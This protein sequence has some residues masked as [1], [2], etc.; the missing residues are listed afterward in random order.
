MSWFGTFG[1]WRRRK[2]VLLESPKGLYV[3]N[4]STSP[5]EFYAAVEAE[6]TEKKVPDLETSRILFAEGGL[7]SSNRE[8]LRMRRERLIFDICAAPFGTSFFFSIRFA[9]I[10]VILYI[11]QLLLALMFF[12]GLGI[13][14]WKIMGL[15]WGMTMF[16][17]NV[18]ALFILLRN[19]VELRLHRLDDFLL[20]LPIFGVIYEVWF[21]AET[22]YRIDTRAMYIEAVRAVVQ[23]HIQEVTGV[24]G[25]QLMEIESFI[26]AELVQLAAAL[27]R[28]SA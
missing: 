25:V 15:A 20:Q 19:V 9:E 3:E 18:A 16:G 21:R 14:Y 11:W 22:F 2:P 5:K 7:L 26:P 24:E 1:F 23:R 13:V 4:F 12:G 27:R 6:L 28:W 8:Y 10:P 17:L